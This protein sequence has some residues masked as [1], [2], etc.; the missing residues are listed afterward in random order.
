MRSSAAPRASGIERGTASLM[1]GFEGR[2]SAED[3]T[4][5]VAY[6]ASLKPE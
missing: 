2:F 6:L 3:V 5:L 4:N 1:P